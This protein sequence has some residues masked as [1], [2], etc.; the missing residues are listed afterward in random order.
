[1][2]RVLI[3]A[4]GVIAM[5]GVFIFQPSIADAYPGPYRVVNANSGKCMVVQGSSNMAT[6]FQWTC[7][8]YPD[9]VWNVQPI[10][11]ATNDTYRLINNNSGKCLVA[12]GNADMAQPFQYD[13]LNYSDQE[14]YLW[15]DGG[16]TD[17]PS[18][19]LV[20]AN[21]G[22]CLVVQGTDDGARLFQ[23]TCLNYPDQLWYLDLS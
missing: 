19:R 3:A 6:A 5:L 8:N 9:Q 14:W 18:Y 1:M 23:Y 13:C 20:N 7:L 15:K 22:K 10:P 16:T 11:S 4:L 17:R 21:S 12:Q 2:R